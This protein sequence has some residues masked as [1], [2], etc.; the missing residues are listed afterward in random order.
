MENDSVPATLAFQLSLLSILF[1]S[2]FLGFEFC[3][4]LVI[5]IMRV[6][7]FFDIIA[8]KLDFYY[9]LLT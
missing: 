7:I 3:L 8:R 1:P 2:D 4:D 9:I 6:C 5:F